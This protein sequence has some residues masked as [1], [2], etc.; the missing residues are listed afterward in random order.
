MIIKANIHGVNIHGTDN[1]KLALNHNQTMVQSKTRRAMSANNNQT[2]LA[3][4]KR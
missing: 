3:T 2:C 1:S 4:T